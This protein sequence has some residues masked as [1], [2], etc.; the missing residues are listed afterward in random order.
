MKGSEDVDC[1]LSSRQ[2]VNTGC[3]PE[4]G[5]KT[6][7]MF[8]FLSRVPANSES[9]A[10]AGARTRL[11]ILSTKFPTPQLLITTAGNHN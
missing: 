1:T 6:L 10:G 5:V 3:A 7:A 2:Y 4:S 11:S 9:A 8:H